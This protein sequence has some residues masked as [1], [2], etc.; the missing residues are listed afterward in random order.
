M[1]LKRICYA[2]PSSAN[3]SKL[4]YARSGC[5]YIQLHKEENDGSPSLVAASATTDLKEC[6]RIARDM[7][8]TAW[9]RYSKRLDPADEQFRNLGAAA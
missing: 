1:I 8:W 7:R 3:A 9:S 5:Y 2:Y 6:E 4:G